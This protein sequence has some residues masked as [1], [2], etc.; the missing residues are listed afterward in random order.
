MRAQ[1][2]LI[3]LV[4][5]TQAI[6]LNEKPAP[7]KDENEKGEKNEEEKKEPVC[8]DY[9]DDGEIFTVCNVGKNETSS[10]PGDI[11]ITPPWAKEKATNGTE[12]S[13]PVAAKGGKDG[14]KSGEKKK[15]VIDAEVKKNPEKV[16]KVPAG[17][18]KV[19][20]KD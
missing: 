5:T 18:Y 20:E 16:E 11:S 2:L 10:H 1:L 12:D 4:A 3:A 13:Q 14:E 19:E 15:K 8:G 9:K 17:Q 6:I 7:K